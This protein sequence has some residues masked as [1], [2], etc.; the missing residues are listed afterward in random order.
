MGR[1]L[2]MGVAITL[3]YMFFL[4][5]KVSTI[6]CYVCTSINH[7][8]LACEDKFEP[9]NGSYYVPDCMGSR[10]DQDGLFPATSCIKLIGVDEP[11]NYTVTVRTCVTNSGGTTSETEIDVVSHCGWIRRISLDGTEMDGC[12]VSCNTDGCNSGGRLFPYVSLT[13]VIGII[14]Y[15]LL[16]RDVA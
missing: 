1:S 3:C 2:V 14:A 7:S 12:V 9:L 5:G 16:N 11:N 4:V 15:K 10:K 8:E 6:G 13:A